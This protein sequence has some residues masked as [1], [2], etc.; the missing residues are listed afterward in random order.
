MTRCYSFYD[1]LG[2]E[3]HLLVDMSVRSSIMMSTSEEIVDIFERLAV[4]SQHKVMHGNL[5]G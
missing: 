2:S 1:V 4:A 5:N 3:G